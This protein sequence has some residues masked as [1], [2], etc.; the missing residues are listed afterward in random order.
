M[1][2][3]QLF[4]SKKSSDHHHLLSASALKQKAIS[5]T[6]HKVTKIS[7]VLCPLKLFVL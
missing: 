7:A 5:P 6:A 3:S 2:D 1:H 4:A